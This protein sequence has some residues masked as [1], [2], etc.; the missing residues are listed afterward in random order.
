M[1]EAI[2]SSPAAIGPPHTPLAMGR[3]A[4]SPYAPNDRLVGWRVPVQAH[5][6]RRHPIQPA[7]AVIDFVFFLLARHSA[8]TLALCSC[9]V[10]QLPFRTVLRCVIDSATPA[11]Q[12]GLLRASTS[13][14]L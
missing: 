7:A 4:P 11:V 13:F 2:F 10:R 9:F 12:G 14:V 5:C 8:S 1:R 6:P 3:S